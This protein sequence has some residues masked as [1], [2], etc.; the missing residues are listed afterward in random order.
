V[1]MPVPSPSWET[2]QKITNPDDLKAFTQ[3][4]AAAAFNAVVQTGATTSTGEVSTHGMRSRFP[5]HR[6]SGSGSGSNISLKGHGQNGQVKP[7]KSKPSPYFQ[8][9]GKLTVNRGSNVLL[10]LATSSTFCW[11]LDASDAITNLYG[12]WVTI[13]QDDHAVYQAE[14]LIRK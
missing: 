8:C 10:V 12:F 9:S 5:G 1:T 14:S 3:A 6:S 4:M 7:V 13:R 11:V 2:L